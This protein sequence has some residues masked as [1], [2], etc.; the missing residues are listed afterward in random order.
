MKR[1]LKLTQRAHARELDGI[2][3]RHALEISMAVA[4]NRLTIAEQVKRSGL[5]RSRVIE[6]R[7]TWVNFDPMK[8][9]PWE[10]R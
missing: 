3:A 2:K 4:A 7:R 6:C 8:L 5:S 10:A 9:Q 1:R